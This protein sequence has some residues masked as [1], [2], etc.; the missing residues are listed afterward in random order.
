M[1]VFRYYVGLLN[2]RTMKMEVHNA[3]LFNMQP[4]IPGKLT[5]CS[6]YKNLIVP[7]LLQDILNQ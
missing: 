1:P 4:V 7:K 3:E 2:K 5:V 6:S